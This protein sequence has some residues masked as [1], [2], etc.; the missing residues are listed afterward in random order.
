[1]GKEVI[2]IHGN[3]NI[4]TSKWLYEL[5]LDSF[6]ESGFIF[7]MNEPNSLEFQSFFSILF[8]IFVT[9]LILIVDSFDDKK[10]DARRYIKKVD[11]TRSKT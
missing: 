11:S 1:M 10:N 2:L 7:F 8:K 6:P 5:S 4:H 9:I 3:N